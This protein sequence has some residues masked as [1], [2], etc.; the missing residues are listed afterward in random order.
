MT[1]PPLRDPLNPETSWISPDHPPESLETSSEFP[2]PDPSNP[3]T[4]HP[5]SSTPRD[6]L[7]DSIESPPTREGWG[8]GGRYLSGQQAPVCGQ[9]KRRV[10]EELRQALPVCNSRQPQSQQVP[11]HALPCQHLNMV[12]QTPCFLA[13]HPASPCPAPPQCLVPSLPTCHL[14]Q[15]WTLGFLLAQTPG[16]YHLLPPS[17]S[18]PGPSPKVEGWGVSHL[19]SAVTL[20]L[21]SLP[22]QSQEVLVLEG[23]EG[24]GCWGGAHRGSLAM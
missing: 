21:H 23:E 12:A 17:R 4:P 1:S 8:E 16:S 19:V 14:A 15:P 5:R 9:G 11:V 24:G 7:E 13:V 22:E 20:A 10:Q 6:P 2:S 3:S 18:F